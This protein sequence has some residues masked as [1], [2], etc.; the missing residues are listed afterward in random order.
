M[1]GRNATKTG[2]QVLSKYSER[3]PRFTVHW[4]REHPEVQMFLNTA[5][6]LYRLIKLRENNGKVVPHKKNP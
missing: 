3:I 1:N 5:I 6:G 4:N 2:Y